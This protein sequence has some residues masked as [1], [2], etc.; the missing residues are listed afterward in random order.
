[1]STTC[2]TKVVKY[3]RRSLIVEAVQW[4]PHTEIEDVIPMC[5]CSGVYRPLELQSSDTCGRAYPRNHIGRTCNRCGFTLKSKPPS[6][7]VLTTAKRQLDVQTGDWIVIEV[8]GEK[9]VCE[10]DIFK[11][12]YEALDD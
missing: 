4:F 7:G 12:R 6:Y 1:M 8:D 3:R 5:R 9:W 2:G 11:A 10:P